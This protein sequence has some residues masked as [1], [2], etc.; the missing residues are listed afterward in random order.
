ME[1]EGGKPMTVCDKIAKCKEKVL[2]TY[3]QKICL[4]QPDD[5]YLNSKIPK[6]WLKSEVVEEVK[7][8]KKID[9]VEEMDKIVRRDSLGEAKS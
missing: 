4:G 9:I 8:P 7:S 5:C 3:F 2:R 1:K 6:E